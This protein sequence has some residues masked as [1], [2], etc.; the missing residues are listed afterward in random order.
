M[1]TLGLPAGGTVTTS[2]CAVRALELAV[3]ALG[4]RERGSD[5]SLDI[6]FLSFFA[7]FFFNSC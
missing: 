4:F 5:L 1:D 7:K 3:R 6:S 2:L